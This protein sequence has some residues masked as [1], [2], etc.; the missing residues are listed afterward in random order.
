MLALHLRRLSYTYSGFVKLHTVVQFQET[1]DITPC[2]LW[3][4]DPEVVS[5]AGR[6]G[7]RI[8]SSSGATSELGGLEFES[9]TMKRGPASSS[10]VRY[11]LIA[12]IEH[13]GASGSGHYV[14]HRR[15]GG[16]WVRCSDDSLMRVS[17]QVAL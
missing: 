14:T 3:A 8:T 13:L 6:Q 12:I 1:L 7:Q 16:G 4:D 10:S 17:L 2:M 9:S 15:D 11:R 5:V